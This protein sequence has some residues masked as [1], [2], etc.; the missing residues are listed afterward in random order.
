MISRVRV[1]VL[2]SRLDHDGTA[3]AI[4]HHVA[5]LLRAGLAPSA[6]VVLR[7]PFAASHD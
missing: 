5:T 2:V 1:E 4:A 6:A 7:V 3:Q